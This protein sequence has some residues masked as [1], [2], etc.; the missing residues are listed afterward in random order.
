M[1]VRTLKRRPKPPA[2][3]AGASAI[4]T[5]KKVPLRH[6]ATSALTAQPIVRRSITPALALVRE[7]WRIGVPRSSAP[8][9]NLEALYVSKGIAA[10]E[11]LRDRGVQQLSEVVDRYMQVQ[12]KVA[13]LRL[14]VQR[15][16]QQKIVG[17]DGELM[18]VAEADERMAEASA[19]VVAETARGSI[20]HQRAEDWLRRLVPWM[21]FADFPVI[22][23]FI[24]MI[25]NVDL[26]GVSSGDGAAIGQSIIPLLTSVAFAVLATAV[27][28]I[29]LHFFANDLRDYKDHNGHLA[30]PKGQARSIPLCFLVLAIL[31]TV[32]AGILMAYRIVHDSIGAGG[33]A[34]GAWVL[35]MF[36][37]VIVL[38]LDVVVFASKFRDGSRLTDEID[39]LAG[40]LGDVAAR[41]QQ[42][43]ERIDRLTPELDVLRQKGEAIYDTTRTKMSAPIQGANQLMLLS[44]SYHQGC[45][46]SADLLAPDGQP[47][48][49]FL[50]PRPVVDTSALD[51]LIAKLRTDSKPIDREESM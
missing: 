51:R 6:I 8:L 7:Q 14:D 46:W 20:K 37:C 41:K 35:G 23:Y 32:C 49:S 36:F 38:A 45:G 28:S 5:K 43:H 31:V 34:I 12:A 16:D 40:Q 22:F 30:I 27:V 9:T 1:A 13:G 33:D 26:A 39:L 42:L 21:P 25:M 2:R 50:S 24:A 18:T 15:A 47:P 11:H 44:R 10:A 3:P 4:Y 48:H 19:L 17:Q 29:A